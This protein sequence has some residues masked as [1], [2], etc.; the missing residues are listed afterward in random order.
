MED[1][2][3]ASQERESTEHQSWFALEIDEAAKAL[4]TSI[5]SGLDT[6]LAAHRLISYG[7]NEL[8]AAPKPSFWKKLLDQF[9]SFHSVASWSLS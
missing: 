8:T 3:T 5:E 9:S 4:Q 1:T 7:P 6:D 2:K